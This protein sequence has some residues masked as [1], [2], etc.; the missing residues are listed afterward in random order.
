MLNTILRVSTLAGN[1]IGSYPLSAFVEPSGLGKEIGMVPVG[2]ISMDN[3]Y[4]LV[5]VYNASLNQ[6][7]LVQVDINTGKITR[8]ADGT[9]AGFAYP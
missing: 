9:L 8:L 4:P 5:A 6:A 3:E 7:V 2:T 1:D